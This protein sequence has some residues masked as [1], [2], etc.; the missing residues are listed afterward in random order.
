MQRTPIEWVLGPNGE[1]GYSW[2]PGGCG[3]SG[4]CPWC[5]AR[6]GVAPRLARICP[7]CGLFAVHWHP[8]RLADLTPRQRPR[9]VFVCSTSD[10]FD[11]ERAGEPLAALDAMAA[12]PQHRYYLLTKQPLSAA[13]YLAEWLRRRS[14]AATLAPWW[15]GVSAEDQAA[16]D[17]RIPALLALRGLPGGDRLTLFASVEPI[18]DEVAAV[19]WLGTVH[20][21]AAGVANADERTPDRLG[22]PFHDPW[23]RGLDWVIVGAE[24]G[25]G[26]VP[27]CWDW[28][29]SLVQ[30]CRGVGLPCFVKDNARRIF[31]GGVAWPQEM[32]GDG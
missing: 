16:A 30:Q 17:R 23:V 8:E 3:C 11:L 15:I 20:E 29:D 9:G 13:R 19:A 25:L 2:N 7:E 4:G 6:A 26:A 10:L 1:Q 24:T 22:L 31:L 12:A 5:Y 27:P 32:P 14:E 18:L 28:V 21:D